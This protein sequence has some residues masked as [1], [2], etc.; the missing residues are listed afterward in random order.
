MI[1]IMKLLLVKYGPI[2][3]NDNDM[4]ITSSEVYN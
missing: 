2:K 1:E 3:S 4:F